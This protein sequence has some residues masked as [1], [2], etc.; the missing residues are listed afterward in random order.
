MKDTEKALQTFSHKTLT[1][2]IVHVIDYI[3]RHW[4]RHVDT[5]VLRVDMVITQSR[6]GHNAA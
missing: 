1:Y 5:L 6:S 2:D 3:I 4:F